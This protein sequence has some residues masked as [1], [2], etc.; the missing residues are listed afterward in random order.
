MDKEFETMRMTRDFNNSCDIITAQEV[1][2]TQKSHFYWTEN[3]ALLNVY[4]RT[5]KKELKKLD[6]AIRRAMNNG[7]EFVTHDYLSYLHPQMRN[8]DFLEIEDECWDIKFDSAL[9][10]PNE[11]NLAKK[12]CIAQIKSCLE[13]L[14]YDV[15]L[16]EERHLRSAIRYK[17]RVAW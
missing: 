15:E 3:T 4:H 13:E 17:L 10:T 9:W 2:E 1:R 8:R 16:G 12:D 7:E 14:G 5:I 6:E 11:A